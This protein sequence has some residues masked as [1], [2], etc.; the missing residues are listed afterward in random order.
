MS[1]AFPLIVAYSTSTC[2]DFSSYF[3][4][5]LRFRF[6]TPHPGYPTQSNDLA[7]MT[8]LQ[9]QYPNVEIARLIF[10]HKEPLVKI[11]PMEYRL[12]LA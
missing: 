6:L 4:F 8:L 3:H 7:I 9:Q 5:V 1:D 10:D 11:V 12:L 2:T